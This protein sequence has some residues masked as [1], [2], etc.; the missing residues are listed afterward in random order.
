[1]SA[2]HRVTTVHTG[3]GPYDLAYGFGAVWVATVHGVSR[4][5]PRTGR[6]EATI[7]VPGNTS[8]WSN[9]A[10]GG[11]SVWYLGATTT[12]PRV[13]RIVPATSAVAGTITLP[14]VTGRA[15]DGLVEAAGTVC[16]GVLSRGPQTVCSAGAGRVFS[17][18][19]SSTLAPRLAAGGAVWIGGSQLVRLDPVI[20]RRVTIAL[21]PGESAVALAS[22]GSTVWAAVESGGRPADLWQIH[23]SRVVRRITLKARLVSALAAWRGAVW[24]MAG[25]P[26]PRVLAVGPNGGV[27]PVAAVDRSDR[28]LL[29]TPNALW[30]TH[31]RAGTVTRLSR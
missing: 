12:G 7:E 17:L 16:V 11:G 28:T 24:I 29:A 3:Y 27:T 23:G 20:R 5:D 2:A 19:G 14:T 8:E 22:D 15:Y 1:M 26:R 30:V 4:L 31:F 25:E 10:V 18:A 9:V 13:T 6:V 21:P